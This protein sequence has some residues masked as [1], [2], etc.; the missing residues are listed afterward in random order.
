MGFPES[1]QYVACL[2]ILTT[3]SH[4]LIGGVALVSVMFGHLVNGTDSFKQ[5]VMLT[6]CGVSNEIFY[7]VGASVLCIA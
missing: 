7:I 2:G 4:L 6:C 3:L 1:K 5:H